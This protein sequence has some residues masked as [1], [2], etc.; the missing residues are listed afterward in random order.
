MVQDAKSYVMKFERCE[1]HKYIRI[2][3][4]FELNILTI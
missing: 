4:S 1:K 2:S 3:L